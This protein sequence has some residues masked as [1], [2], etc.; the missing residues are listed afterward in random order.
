MAGLVV[1]W[2][3][4]IGLAYIIERTLEKR[5]GAYWIGTKK[6]RDLWPELEGYR[7]F[8][9]QTDLGQLQQ[10]MNT[11]Q[12]S[13]THAALLPYAIVLNLPIRW[14]SYLSS[15]FH[16]ASATPRPSDDETKNSQTN[17]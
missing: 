12:L 5:I 15:R 1:L 13:T 17:G 11:A 10:Q 7:L 6:L 14:E 4:Y 8:L 3:A 9:R 2:P 16:A